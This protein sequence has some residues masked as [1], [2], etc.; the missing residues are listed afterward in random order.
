[1]MIDVYMDDIVDEE[2]VCGR[3]TLIWNHT[4][5]G[6]GS[7]NETNYKTTL[8]DENKFLLETNTEYTYVDT[9]QGCQ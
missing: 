9:Q 1:M 6:F 8:K 5:F 3:W 4:C 2:D 7:G